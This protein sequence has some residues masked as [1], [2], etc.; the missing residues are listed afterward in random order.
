MALAAE[1]FL[2]NDFVVSLGPVTTKARTTSS[3]AILSGATVRCYIAA[4]SARTA[5]PI[6]AA[7]DFTMTEDGTT[8]VY[9]VAIDG[10]LITTHLAAFIDQEVWFHFTVNG[11]DYRSREST[12]VRAERAA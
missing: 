12:T 8:G 10:S 7:L 3:P 9:H 11:T 4:T 5:A 2:D 6:H 1:I